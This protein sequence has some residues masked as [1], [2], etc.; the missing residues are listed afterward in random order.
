MLD[1]VNNVFY[2]NVGTGE[3]KRGPLRTVP[4][5]YQRV[6]YIES[7]GTQYIEAPISFSSSN[8]G[9]ELMGAIKQT[10]PDA[11]LVLIYDSLGTLIGSGR[12]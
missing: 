2:M 11:A 10:M 8:I 4:K 6:E 12:G 5:I 7:T 1:L 9:L 3:F